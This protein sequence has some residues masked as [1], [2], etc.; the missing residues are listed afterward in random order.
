MESK[1][2]VVEKV[3]PYGIFAAE[4]WFG[5]RQ[6]LT[7]QF[8]ER[9]LSYAVKTDKSK[10]GKE[11]ILAAVVEGRIEQV[12]TVN[13]RTTGSPIA[14]ISSQTA[15]EGSSTAPTKYGKP[16]GAYELNQDQCIRR[17]GIIQATLQSPIIAHLLAKL[18]IDDMDVAFGYVE[19]L[20]NRALKYVE[21]KDVANS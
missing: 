12:A 13:G 10:T 7:P 5:L 20:A 4:Q 1:S 14:N 2:L 3:G 18:N 15:N 19:E 8:F 6:P 17:S 16:L 11:Y 9:G 21:N